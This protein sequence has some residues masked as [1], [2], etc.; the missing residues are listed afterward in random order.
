VW[1][2]W[3]G[4]EE[5]LA[6]PGDDV[7]SLGVELYQMLTGRLPFRGHE[8]ELVQAILHA[9]P[10]APHEANPRVP[11]ALGELCLRMLRK[12]PGERFADAWALEAALE[13]ALKQADAVWEV[14]LCEAWGPQCATTVRRDD[15]R[16]TGG[17]WEAWRER[18]A[19]YEKR[20]VRGRPLPP[21]EAPTL[22][23]PEEGPPAPEAL[24]PPP[25]PGE[26]SRE[27]APSAAPERAPDMGDE[28]ASE[29]P[30]PAPPEAAPDASGQGSSGAAARGGG[31]VPAARS[32]VLQALGVLGVLG[33]CVGLAVSLLP[34]GG[35]RPTLPVGTPR[36]DPR[37][38]FY[39]MGLEPGGQEVAP[40]WKRPEG[41]GGAAPLVA[42]TPAP[43]APATRSEDTRVKT[44][45]K[46]PAR[47]QPPPPKETGNTV[48]KAG[49]L[50]LC[51]T[52]A[53]GCVGPTSAVPM[54][55]LPG[56]AECPPGAVETMKA[57]G[58]FPGKARIATWPK[59]A[60][61]T[62]SG[63]FVT[64]REGPVTLANLDPTGIKLP[65]DTRLSG[66]L[67]FGAGR[68]HGR[69]TQARTPGGDTYPVCM[70]LVDS[71]AWHP[72]DPYGVEPEPPEGGF[73]G[74][75][76]ARIVWAQGVVPVERF[77]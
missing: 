46:A 66:V 13:E 56:P 58:L 3:R 2:A 44:P 51:C 74:D 50:A 23:A 43:V 67:F 15:V 42:P 34:R 63:N 27:A 48:C 75:G 31:D 71:Y 52:L 62:V 35:E 76:T 18:L 8:E 39:P 49:T 29:A 33:L 38:E 70:V 10:Q 73:F 24:A 54:R 20:L 45:A 25:T 16:L 59:P 19:S 47:P 7:W 55:P 60:N 21:E 9:K 40:P 4:E 22:A 61:D 30:P 57:L 26:P 6:C 41:D 37:P 5:S 11:R 36:A 28:R 69:F 14:P 17:E 53:S 64:V 12:Q 68:V 77:E 32:R 1:R 72:P 65:S